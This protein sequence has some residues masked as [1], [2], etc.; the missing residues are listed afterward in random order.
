MQQ[1]GGV[2]IGR[3]GGFVQALVSLNRSEDKGTLAAL[4]RLSPADKTPFLNG[5][6][7]PFMGKWMDSDP[8]KSRNYFLVAGIYA[9]HPFHTADPRVD[10]ATSLRRYARESNREGRRQHT[11]KRFGR[12]IAAPWPRIEEEIVSAAILMGE[13]VTPINYVILLKDLAGWKRQDNAV[14]YRWAK[15]F[16]RE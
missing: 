15:N 7:L 8:E 16:Y 11:M 2:M 13:S 14:Q 12:L 6:V 10:F 5:N 9:R 3:E 1:A 4:R